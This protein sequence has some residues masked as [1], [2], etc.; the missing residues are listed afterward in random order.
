MLERAK[1][2]KEIGP[3]EKILKNKILN[4]ITEI[5]ELYGFYPLETP[6]LQRYDILASKYAGG[7]EILKETFQLKD[8]GNRELALRYDLTVP[9]AI[10]MALNPNTKLPFKRYEIGKVFR[11]GPISSERFREFWQCDV[12]IVGSSSM[13]AE[14][15]II[16]LAFRVFKELELSIT[17]KVNNRK[18]LD[19]I[20]R[21]AGITE[22]KS[23]EVI[24]SIDK[25]DKIGNEGVKKELLE[26]EL[27]EEQVTKI[28]T[29][30]MFIGS[31]KDKIIKLKNLLGENEGITEI[32]EIINYEPNVRFEISL[33]R[34]LAYYTGTIFEI[35]LNDPK[36][37]TSFGGGGRYDNMV[38]KFL[39]SKTK[40]PAV[41][42]AFGLDRIAIALK[43]KEKTAAKVFIIPI[44]TEKE[45]FLLANVLRNN[46][47]N[48]DTDLM[49][50]SISKNLDYANS[51]EIPYVI[52]LG[53]EELKQ[54]KYKLRNMKNG[55]EELLDFPEIVERLKNG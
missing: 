12:D 24:L 52:F 41:G 54:K 38:G 39:D 49:S 35:E 31:N 2:T 46:G 1:G 3:E 50:R 45:S 28:L 47:I 23:Q 25:L 19:A 34:G 22:D 26:K 29:P 42:I 48:T 33:A 9:L 53:E 18:I 8:Q 6:T 15:E 55:R 37:K 13:M 5:F 11:D 21:Y 40:I 16:S 51:L 30:I 36:F 32:Q 43:S 10:Y 7:A 17:L 4:K 44:K 20:T 27:T 14:A